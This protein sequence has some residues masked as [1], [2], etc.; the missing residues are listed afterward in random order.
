MKSNNIYSYMP[1]T[2]LMSQ[3]PPLD[4]QWIDFEMLHNLLHD[5]LPLA[6]FTDLGTIWLTT[7]K[8]FPRKTPLII[9]ATEVLS[10]PLKVLLS[11]HC[12]CRGG[13]NIINYAMLTDLCAHALHPRVA[14]LA[15]P[16]PKSKSMVTVTLVNVITWHWL[17]I[18]KEVSEVV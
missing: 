11:I 6:G 2:K 4:Q 7:L 17:L 5:L 9:I 8:Y 1:H 12:W 14:T 18:T 16:Q 10:C 15:T 3:P 13:G